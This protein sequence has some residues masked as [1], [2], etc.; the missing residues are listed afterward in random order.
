MKR[1]VSGGHAE[2]IER[3]FAA[4]PESLHALLRADFLCG[5]DPRFVGLHR[6]DDTFYGSSYGTTAHCAYPIHQEPIL[7]VDRVTTVVLPLLSTVE[8]VIHELG[9]V[10]DES[11][12]LAIEPQVSSEY[13][14]SNRPEC[15]AEAF[16]A[17]V[18]PGY[19][20]LAKSDYENFS[21]LVRSLGGELEGGR[22]R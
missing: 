4:I 20:N 12:G 10:L 16:T 13:A 11:L 8:T 21:A 6:F 7:P 17:F 22:A 2:V 14:K 18:S 19:G 9:H 15:F 3:A 1:M 5:V